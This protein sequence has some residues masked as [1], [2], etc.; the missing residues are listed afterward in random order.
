MRKSQC[1]R[2]RLPYSRPCHC[3]AQEW[4]CLT[5]HGSILSLRTQ[6][7]LRAVSTGLKGNHVNFGGSGISGFDPGGGGA[8]G[9]GGG[10]VD[11]EE[12][13]PTRGK[14][15]EDSPHWLEL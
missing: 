12:L 9:E 1:I 10:G 14:G 15:K 3:T 8:G 2:H 6:D 7:M 4:T 5:V 11:L 13:V